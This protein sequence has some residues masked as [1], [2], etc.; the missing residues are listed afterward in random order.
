MFI[1]GISEGLQPLDYNLNTYP[2]E[3]PNLRMRGFAPPLLHTYL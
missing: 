3:V 2:Y 1:G